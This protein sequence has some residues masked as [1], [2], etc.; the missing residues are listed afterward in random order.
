MNLLH[1]QSEGCYKVNI[2][3]VCNAD[4]CWSFMLSQYPFCS[5]IPVSIPVCVM[6]VAVI[7][8]DAS[9]RESVVLIFIG[10]IDKIAVLPG[11][12]QGD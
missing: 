5:A 8:S 4:S 9:D 2:V 12:G 10:K 6:Q 3:A 1:F 7:Y 11:G